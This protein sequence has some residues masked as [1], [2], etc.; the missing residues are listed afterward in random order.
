MKISVYTC[1]TNQYDGLRNYRKSHNP[2]IDFIC[3]TDNPNLIYN[4]K[5]WTIKHI[6]NDLMTFPKVKQQRLMKILPHRYLSNYDISIWVD[7]NIEIKCDIDDFLKNIDLEKYSF[8]TRKH[9][10]RNCIYKEAKAVLRY[11]K[12]K[13]NNINSQISEYRK[14]GFPENFGLVETAVI[15]RKHNEKD[16]MILDNRWG[17]E[18]IE[19]SH[20]DQMSF[21]YVR[22]KTGIDIGY[23]ELKKLTVDSNFRW[24]KHGK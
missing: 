6:P 23:F 12:D 5:G 14:E 2:N 13:V 9:P 10:S 20:R 21:D 24:S 11:R 17:K 22:W 3:Y 19:K 4:D 7:G 15:I 18:I 8:Y 16:C 1:I